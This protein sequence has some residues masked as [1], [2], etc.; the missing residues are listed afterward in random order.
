MIE[1]EPLQQ[2]DRTWVRFQGRKLSYFSGCDY[3]RLASHPRV[4]AALTAGAERY[5][6]NVAAS[7]LTTGN[8]HLYSEL[9]GELAGFFDAQDALL[10]PTGYLTNLAAAQA[11]AGSFSHAL[12]DAEAHPSLIDA[13]AMLDCPVVRFKHRDAQDA[14]RAVTRCGPEARLILL[15]DGLFARTGHA[16]P[17]REYARVLPKDG[18]MLVDDAHGA[19]VLGRTGKGTLEYAGVS[20]ARVVQTITLSKALGVYG[21]AILGTKALRKRVV[22]RSRLFVGATPFPLPLANAAIHAV[23]LLGSDKI[24]RQRLD[25]N[26]AFVKEALR[27]AGYAIPDAPGPIVSF[28]PTDNRTTREL[29]GALLDAKIFPPHVRYPGGPP[30]GCFRFAISS[31]HTR[32]Q[33]EGL[34]RALTSRSSLRGRLKAL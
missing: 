26:T 11:L 22:D 7:R 15:T 17:L 8:H 21:G 9:E 29:R 32:S 1:P 28:A 6:L 33:L 34:I 23:R 27:E 18:R 25:G 14:A 20:R 12:L 16:A 24:L 4:L 19:G 13:A 30:A 31:E 5:G 2:I 3:F 10:V